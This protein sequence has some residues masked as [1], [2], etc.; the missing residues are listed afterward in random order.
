MLQYLVDRPILF[1]ASVMVVSAVLLALDSR[2][3]PGTSATLIRAMMLVLG[4]AA[5]LVVFLHALP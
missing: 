1:I 2:A 5:M 4:P 3:K